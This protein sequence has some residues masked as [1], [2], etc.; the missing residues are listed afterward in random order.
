[1][2]TGFAVKVLVQVRLK[3]LMQKHQAT[4]LIGSPFLNVSVSQEPTSNLKQ[5]SQNH[6]KKFDK[7]TEIF[8]WVG[9]TLPRLEVYQYL[10]GEHLP[11]VHILTN[12]Y[13]T[14][15]D[16]CTRLKAELANSGTF[17]GV[18]GGKIG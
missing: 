2:L 4:S 11:L 9:D 13:V 15:L 18:F 10:H 3:L 5:M 6:T 1:M 14:V 7:L 16:I 17:R 12:I 8:Q